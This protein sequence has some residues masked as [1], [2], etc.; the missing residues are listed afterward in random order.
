METLRDLLPDVDVLVGL[1]PEELARYLLRLARSNL[2]N[3][4]FNLTF[5]R[6]TGRKV[7]L[8]LRLVESL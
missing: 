6:K 2:Q 8:G 5:P 4:M 1:P 7:T 3:G